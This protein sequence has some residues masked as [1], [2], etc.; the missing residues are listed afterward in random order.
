MIN[1][2]SFDVFKNEIQFRE[3]IVSYSKLL[4]DEVFS[5]DRNWFLEDESIVCTVKLEKNI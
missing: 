5:K 2:F 4:I 1:T 3:R